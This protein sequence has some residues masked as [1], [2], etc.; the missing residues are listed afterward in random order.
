MVT[1]DIAQNPDRLFPADP[2]QREVARR[3]YAPVPDVVFCPT[4][5]ISAA[6]APDYLGLSNVACVG[7][8]WLTPM[9]AVA[10]GGCG[11]ITRRAREAAALA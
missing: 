10:A 7:G 8:S 5:G 9:D 1:T 3:L 6:N 11:E 2:A 4:G